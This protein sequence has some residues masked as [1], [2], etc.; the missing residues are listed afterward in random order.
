MPIRPQGKRHEAS[1][2]KSFDRISFFL[3]DYR[4]LEREHQL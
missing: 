4:I 2:T 1:S 3:K